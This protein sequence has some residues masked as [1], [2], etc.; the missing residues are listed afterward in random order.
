MNALQENISIPSALA[1]I[2][3]V[4]IYLPC[5][6]ASAVFIKETGGYKYFGYLFVFTTITAYILAFIT[7]N[8]TTFIGL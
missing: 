7:F 2:V 6:A 5:L 4:M 1:F 8:I 3:F